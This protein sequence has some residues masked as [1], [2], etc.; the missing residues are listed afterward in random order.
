M[1]FEQITLDDLDKI[2]GLQPKDW[3][4]IV[5]DFEFY[6]KSTFC[7]PI[8]VVVENKIAG[9]GAF[10][11]FGNTS[12][13]AHI[14]VHISWRNKGIGSGIVNYFL[15]KAGDDSIETCSLIATD[16]GKPVYVKAGF[17]VVTEY[18]FLQQAGQWAGRPVSKNVV[19]FEEKY[20]AG[21]YE[22]DKTVSGETRESL[23][24][25]YLENSFLYVDNGK[26]EG[27]YLPGLKEGLIFA[28]TNKAGLELMNF[29]YLG[30]GRAVLPAEN[31]CG[32]EFLMQN[33]FLEASRGTRMVFGKDLDWNPT[34]VYGR[35]G[36]N[37]G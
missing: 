24:N 16:L 29:K 14:I 5:P 1:T 21:I 19:P 37:L 25:G 3:G 30:T 20:R 22:L 15:K 12:W 28:D 31:T 17:R 13:L 7:T 2:R 11:V 8:K 36:G 6:I 26:V 33:G 32:I 27:Y 34:K 10:I 18:V 9:I 4:D 35:I 23:L